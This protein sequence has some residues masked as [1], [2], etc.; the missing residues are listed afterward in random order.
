MQKEK[1]VLV[2]KLVRSQP[3]RHCGTSHCLGT[4]SYTLGKFGQGGDIDLIATALPIVFLAGCNPVLALK[5][6]YE[7]SLYC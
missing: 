5:P 7:A 4:V 1:E 2:M 6:Q 3:F